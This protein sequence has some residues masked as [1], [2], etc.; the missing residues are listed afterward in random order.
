MPIYA[1][2]AGSRAVARKA[3]YVQEGFMP[4][5]ILK[6]G[7]AIDGVLYGACRPGLPLRAD[8]GGP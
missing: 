5:G 3:G 1:R 8:P 4:Y 2:N 6:D 7:Q